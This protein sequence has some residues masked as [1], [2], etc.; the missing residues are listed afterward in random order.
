MHKQWSW[1]VL[2]N[3]YVIV[4]IT[5][6]STGVLCPSWQNKVFR[7]KVNFKKI[8]SSPGRKWR[9][10]V[11]F[12]WEPRNGRSQFSFRRLELQ[13]K[14]ELLQGNATEL[15]WA[16]N[17]RRIECRSRSVNHQLSSGCGV[18]VREWDYSE[19]RC[20]KKRRLRAKW[21]PCC[22]LEGGWGCQAKSHCTKL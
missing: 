7:R 20:R 13:L 11:R 15:S 22:R 5:S 16:D 2:L 17:L 8:E 19:V 18:C 4:P 10:C 6:V 1:L 3:C 12:W 21:N 14:V 9:V